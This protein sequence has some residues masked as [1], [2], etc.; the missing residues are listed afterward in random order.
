MEEIIVELL[1]EQKVKQAIQ[2]YRDEYGVS[3]EIAESIIDSYKSEIE[4]MKPNHRSDTAFSMEEVAMLDAMIFND[5]IDA[6]VEYLMEKY[7]I[8]EREA[9][10]SLNEINRNS[11][12]L[13]SYDLNTKIIT[14][15]LETGQKTLAI[16]KYR[17]LY[18]VDIRAAQTQVEKIEDLL[19]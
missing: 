18:D 4:A 13:P 16:V 9:T 6:A 2:L 17:E 3:W 8:N 19:A 7:D 1:Q 14:D 10:A 12:H 11:K 5:E 15:L